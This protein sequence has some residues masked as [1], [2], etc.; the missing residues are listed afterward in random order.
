M[1]ICK[2]NGLSILVNAAD[3]G[4]EE[5]VKRSFVNILS[6]LDPF[7]ALLLDKIY[8]QVDL[9]KDREVFTTFLPQE[10]YFSRP[11]RE[12]IRPPPEVEV[13]IGNLARL[14]CVTSAIAFGGVAMFSAVHP[15]HLGRHFYAACSSSLTE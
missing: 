10:L 13:S 9:E 7:D 6:Q 14:G 1:S 2:K 12:E 5:G 15:T 3:E 4:F 8:S 11:N